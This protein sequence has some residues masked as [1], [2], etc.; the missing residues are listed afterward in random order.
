MGGVLAPSVEQ[1]GGVGGVAA[2]PFEV[3]LIFEAIREN[4]KRPDAF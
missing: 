1:R 4:E 2:C 3:I